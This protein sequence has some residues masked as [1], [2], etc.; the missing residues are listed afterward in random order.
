MVLLCAP[1]AAAE[2]SFSPAERER[3]QKQATELDKQVDE[4]FASGNLAEAMRLA[5]KSLEIHERLYP[6]KAYPKGHPNLAGGLNQLGL[7]LLALGE[8]TKAL[9]YFKKA[10][11]MN[12]RL[13]PPEKFKDGHASLAASFGAL[14]VLL[15][16]VGEPAK[17]LPYFEKALAMYQRLYPPDQF[18]D[19]HPDLAC[20]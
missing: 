14:G 16:K 17:A 8:P 10:L 13:H 20:D 19:G 15:R 7:L 5:I 3:L 6:V 9:P 18:P 2:E 1:H 11:A 12:E 4:Q